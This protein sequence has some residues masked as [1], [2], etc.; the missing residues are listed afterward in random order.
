VLE[1]HLTEGS[2]QFLAMSGAERQQLVSGM[3]YKKD[4]L[5]NMALAQSFYSPYLLIELIDKQTFMS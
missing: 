1:F 4:S 5:L 2:N 3:I